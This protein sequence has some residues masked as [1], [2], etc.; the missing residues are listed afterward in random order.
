[1]K[2]S[3]RV[4]SSLAQTIS[5]NLLIHLS[6]VGARTLRSSKV[7]A[8]YVYTVTTL[9]VFEISLCRQFINS[10]ILEKK[11]NPSHLAAKRNTK[12]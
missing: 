1:M 6:L 3:S 2:N 9:D 5:T 7:L 4:P 12:S 11:K 8:R 10:E